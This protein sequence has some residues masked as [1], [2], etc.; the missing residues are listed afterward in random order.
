MQGCFPR[1]QKSHVMKGALGIGVQVIIELARKSAR[2]NVKVKIFI[3]ANGSL[4]YDAVVFS[5]GKDTCVQY[6]NVRP[7]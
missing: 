4:G 5:V 2:S 1:R 3:I 6:K 7:T